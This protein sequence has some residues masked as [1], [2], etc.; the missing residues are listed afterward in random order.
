MMYAFRWFLMIFL[1]VYPFNYIVRLFD[2]FFFYGYDIVFS[3]AICS[4]KLLQGKKK[5]RITKQFRKQNTNYQTQK[6]FIINTDQLIACKAFDTI[7]EVFKSLG[8]FNSLNEDG[9]VDF[10]LE[11]RIESNTLRKLEDKYDKLLKDG[12]IR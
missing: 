4:I 8:K 11:H 9:L 3:I 5:R 2:L 10:I 12:K 6:P 7:M 1:E